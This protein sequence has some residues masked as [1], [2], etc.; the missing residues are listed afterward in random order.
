[1][2]DFDRERDRIDEMR[3]LSDLAVVG[4]ARRG[5]LEDASAPQQR[6]LT[7]QQLAQRAGML[8]HGRKSARSALDA[9]EAMLSERCATRGERAMIAKWLKIVRR[10]L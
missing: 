5:Q 3:E 6:P 4:R 9:V 2:S 10:V 8:E 1:M 7:M